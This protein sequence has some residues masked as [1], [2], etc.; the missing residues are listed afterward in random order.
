MLP[1]GS[2]VV[3]DHQSFAMLPLDYGQRSVGPGLRRVRSHDPLRAGSAVL[4]REVLHP[5]GE[6]PRRGQVALVGP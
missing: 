4:L 3:M 2:G 1:R 5:L 6:Y